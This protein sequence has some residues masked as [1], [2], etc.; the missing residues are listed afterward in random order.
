MSDGPAD[1]DTLARRAAQFIA[2]GTGIAEHDVAIV[3]GSGWAPAVAALG[4]PTAVLPMAELPGF[5]P[6]TAVGHT[7]QVLSVGIGAHRVLVLAGRVHAYEG[8]DLLHVVHPVR[9]ACAAG[10]RV[11]VLTNAAGAVRQN[12]EVGQPV[13]IS[14]H[15]NLTAR[16]PLVGAQFV[17]LVDAYA[18]RLRALA[19]EVDPELTEGVY[20]GLPGP[21]YETPAEIR[22]LRTLGADLVGMSTVLEAIAAREAGLEVLGISLVT[23]AAAGMTG[24]P[25]SAQEV[26]DA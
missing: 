12:F 14:D 11:V 9:T 21:H 23:N 18:P 22:M 5:T 15:L 7:G 16:S 3:L 17:D 26:I 1:P 24:E 4:P 13:L 19:R 10:A 6:P 20:A 8:H 2:E 25:L